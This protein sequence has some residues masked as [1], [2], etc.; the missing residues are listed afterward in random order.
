MLMNELI[1][2][3]EGLQKTWTAMIKFTKLKI[4]SKLCINL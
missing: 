3:I 1:K 4:G 2:P